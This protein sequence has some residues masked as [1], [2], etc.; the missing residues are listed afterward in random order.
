MITGP[1]MGGKSCYIKQVALLCIMA[2]IG[3]FVPASSA[4]LGVL[5]AV[6]TRLYIIC[7]ITLI[8]MYLT[9]FIHHRMGA[10]DNI[11]RGKSTFMVELMVGIINNTFPT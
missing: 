1:N 5:D 4:R 6:Y 11:H 10:S 2:Q 8:I 7:Y 9:S 3:S